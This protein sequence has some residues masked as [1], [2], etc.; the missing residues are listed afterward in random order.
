MALLLGL[1]STDLLANDMSAVT[2]VMDILKRNTHTSYRGN[3][4][5]D[6]SIYDTSLYLWLLT[7]H[8]TCA[9]GSQTAPSAS[10]LSPTAMKR[11]RRRI[12]PNEFKWTLII[13][14]VGVYSGCSCALHTRTHR[15][16]RLQ[17]LSFQLSRQ[18]SYN[19]KCR[20]NR[21]TDD[22]LQSAASNLS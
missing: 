19:E 3:W 5:E 2:L 12:K 20:K 16:I 7:S 1:F 22:E 10:Y 13:H 11:R 6:D 8:R 21:C 17:S 4:Q 15:A 18:S 9:S 14:S